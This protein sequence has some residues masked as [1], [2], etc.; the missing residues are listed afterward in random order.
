[1]KDLQ[2]DA[3]GDLVVT[4]NDLRFVSGKEL[5][6]QKARL[7]LSTNKGEWLLNADEGINFRAILVKNPNHDEILD[8]VRDGLRQIDETF[9][10][11]EHHFETVQRHLIL[12]FKAVNDRGEEIAL[13]VGDAQGITEDGETVT[14][15]VCSIDANDVLNAGDAFKALC[16][17]NTDT[18]ILNATVS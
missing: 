12:T 1:M 7:V 15:L 13:A 6:V 3:R 14:V 9:E 17:C 10:I 16:I 18:L 8:T 11:V 4:K 2:V 5:T